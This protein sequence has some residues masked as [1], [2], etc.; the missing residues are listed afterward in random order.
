[1]LTGG[2]RMKHGYIQNKIFY[3]ALNLV[4][5][6][7]DDLWLWRVALLI[8]Q[9]LELYCEAA[10]HAQNEPTHGWHT[11]RFVNADFIPRLRDVGTHRGQ[12]SGL[13]TG[14]MF[15]G[16]LG[17]LAQGHFCRRML[18]MKNS[19][20]KSWCYSK[21]KKRECRKSLISLVVWFNVCSLWH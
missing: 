4:F 19:T 11:C 10:I 15:W 1:M 5:F 16:A 3:H 13:G 8:P 17:I 14:Q 9:P 7:D 12:R 2:T 6:G 18:A 20:N 21:K